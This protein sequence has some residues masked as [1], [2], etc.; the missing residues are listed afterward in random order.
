MVMVLVSKY[1]FSDSSP[2]EKQLYL[3]FSSY[4]KSSYLLWKCSSTDSGTIRKWNG[5]KTRALTGIQLHGPYEK[6]WLLPPCYCPVPDLWCTPRATWPA[7]IHSQTF[8]VFSSR[9][10]HFSPPGRTLPRSQHY[11]IGN[12]S[13]E[14]IGTHR[15]RP[16]PEFLN[17]PKG[18]CGVTAS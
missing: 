18:V 9:L 1:C 17:P 16:N 6:L 12:D 11:C 13:R 10:V 4:F 8:S 3:S 2:L 14:I 5:S 7:A 15:S